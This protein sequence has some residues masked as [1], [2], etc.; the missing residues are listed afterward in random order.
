MVKAIILIALAI[1]L[2]LVLREVLTRDEGGN[3]R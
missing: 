3:K 2:V 1:W